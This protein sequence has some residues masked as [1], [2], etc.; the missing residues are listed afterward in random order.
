MSIS[1]CSNKTVFTKRNHVAFQIWPMVTP[2]ADDGLWSD[3]TSFTGAVPLGKSLTPLC[4][5]FPFF[6]GTVTLLWVL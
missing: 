2:S 3:T 5:S 6:M 4:L 1:L